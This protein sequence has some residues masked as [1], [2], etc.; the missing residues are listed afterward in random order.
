MVAVLFFTRILPAVYIE[1][2]ALLVGAIHMLLSD[3]IADT[4]LLL[5][6][7]MLQIFCKKF[8]ELYGNIYITF[9]YLQ[10]CFTNF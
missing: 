4:K 9:I 5:A 7:N 8:Q 2:L 6:E 10:Y 1:H 3:K